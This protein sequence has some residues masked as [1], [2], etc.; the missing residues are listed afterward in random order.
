M[1]LQFVI[2][3]ADAL[4]HEARFISHIY[5]EQD[6]QNALDMMDILIDDYD[7]QKPLINILANSIEQWE[8]ND[9]GF[10]AFNAQVKALDSD[11]AVLK[12]LIAQYNL[13]ASDLENEIGSKSL[14]SM[15]LNGT[16]NLTTK[17]IRALS[18]RFH[19]DPAI[20]IN[21]VR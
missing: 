8:D 20:F 12:V 7:N 9:E 15:I 11:V 21:I 1:N 3:K 10:E 17:H 16:R 18:K 13:K 6:Y 19:L 2:Q 4:L 5:D 14:V